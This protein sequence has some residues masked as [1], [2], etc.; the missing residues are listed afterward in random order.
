[1]AGKSNFL[2]D[3]ILNHVYRTT[4]YTPPATVYVALFTTMPIDAGTGG[5]EVTGTGYARVGVAT[6]D[7][8]WAAPSA[9][10]GTTRQ[11]S[12]VNQISFG[13]AGSDWAPSGTP[14]V[15]FGLYDASTA[16]NYLGGAA[17]AASKII[18]SGDPVR[19]AAGALVIT[20][21]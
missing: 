17:F 10:A 20:E 11:T 4:T 6:D 19:F 14:C 21:D 12:N 16:G 15:G 3:A 1:M 7:A 5:V 9:G 18:Q 13:T 2:A 8:Q